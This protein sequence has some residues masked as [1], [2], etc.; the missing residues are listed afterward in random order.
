MLLSLIH[1]S[2]HSSLLSVLLRYTSARYL[3]IIVSQRQHGTQTGTT[4]WTNKK[5]MTDGKAFGNS[6]GNCTELR[7]S[8][9]K[10]PS[11]VLEYARILLP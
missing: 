10:L 6:D 5:M 9:Y 2:F 7:E 1:L 4:Q 3:S 8:M 11:T